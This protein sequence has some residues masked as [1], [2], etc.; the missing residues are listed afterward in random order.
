MFADARQCKIRNFW[1]RFQRHDDGSDEDTS[2]LDG[3]RIAVLSEN[4]LPAKYNRRVD[5]LDGYE[6]ATTYHCLRL[7]VLNIE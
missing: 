2:P 5:Q 3:F 6:E 7:D 1:Y 4:D